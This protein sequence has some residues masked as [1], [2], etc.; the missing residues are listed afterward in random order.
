M[1]WHSETGMV[2][3]V[4]GSTTAKDE[5]G[6]PSPI[7]AMG[8]GTSGTS[9]TSGRDKGLVLVIDFDKGETDNPKNSQ[10]H[11]QLGGT[12]LAIVAKPDGTKTLYV[13]TASADAADIRTSLQKTYG[14]PSSTEDV[15]QAIVNLNDLTA[16]PGLIDIGTSTD[17]GEVGKTVVQLSN[18]DG[19]GSLRLLF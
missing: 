2:Y 9:G 14:T 13:S 12:R 16:T 17:P 8:A 5:H 11:L 4:Y 3:L 19:S 10:Q 1:P 7:S 6:D 18:L 15:F